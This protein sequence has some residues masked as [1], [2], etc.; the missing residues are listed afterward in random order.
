MVRTYGNFCSS[1]CVDQN[2]RYEAYKLVLVR[3]M[4]P[5]DEV[6]N[7]IQLKSFSEDEAFDLIKMY[8]LD[9]VPVTVLEE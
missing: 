6:L 8:K 3:S 5:T 9:P 7:Q 1:R 2:A 4:F